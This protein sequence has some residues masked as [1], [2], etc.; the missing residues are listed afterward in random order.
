[1]ANIHD[2][3]KGPANAADRASWLA[4]VPPG[5]LY[6]LAGIVGLMLAL[7]IR[8]VGPGAWQT[9]VQLLLTTIGVLLVGFGISTRLQDG[10]TLTGTK[11]TGAV[12]F[13]L[14]GILGL[15]ALLLGGTALLVP[16]AEQRQIDDML[17]T[18][19]SPGGGLPEGTPRP[20]PWMSY[21]YLV[22]L[23]LG[24]GLALALGFG[25]LLKWAFR[26]QYET[27][28]QP[29]GEVQTSTI[30]LLGL[31]AVAG[32]LA[33]LGLDP[34]WDSL[35]S[36]LCVLSLVALVGAMLIVLPMPWR[37]VVASLLLL[38]HFGGIATAITAVAPPN[39]PAP[40]V[41]TKIW[42]VFYRPYLQFMYMNN[43]YHFYSPE[44]GPASVLWA[45]L[46]YEGG[47]RKFIQL[48]SRPHSPVQMYYQRLLAV[49]ES[50]NQTAPPRPDMKTVEERRWKAE[51]TQGIPIHT[52]F[53]IHLQYREPNDLGKR[54]IQ[55]Y[56]RFLARAHPE[57]DGRPLIRIKLYRVTHLILTGEQYAQGQ[58]PDA[59]QWY[60]P[61]FQGEFTPDGILLNANDSLLYW[62]IPILDDGPGNY[63][64]RHVKGL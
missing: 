59:P 9:P 64:V 52:G 62:V 4:F 51:L 54:L 29:A 3:R 24:A 39:A 63:L 32:L 36:L 43:A 20:Y 28:E 48:P 8:L 50:I 34:A 35:R 46:E 31:G 45:Y 1:M 18:P 38:L 57:K 19:L 41:A 53:P 30:L 5:G 33:Y 7:A 12:L 44:P 60:L 13:R 58:R 40:W 61:Y 37:K 14:L 11:L 47:E 15:T 10:G 55:S 17:R 22:V 49:T 27:D 2:N 21:T 6:V 42:M 16:T 23:V 26:N 25:L 56:V